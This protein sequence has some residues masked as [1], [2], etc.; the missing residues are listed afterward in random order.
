MLDALTTPV[1]RSSRPPA[2]EKCWGCQ[3]CLGTTRPSPF[4]SSI[5]DPRK[6]VWVASSP[7]PYPALWT[8]PSSRSDLGP[9][10]SGNSNLSPGA[11]RAGRD[12]RI[13]R[14]GDSAEQF[15]PGPSTLF[16]ALHGG[17]QGAC[18]RWPD[19][20]VSKR[21]PNPFTSSPSSAPGRGQGPRPPGI[22]SGGQTLHSGPR[23]GTAPGPACASR[24]PTPPW[25]NLRPAPDGPDT[26]P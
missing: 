14:I 3:P 11:C 17:R 22:T 23:P 12:R 10:H 4:R 26:T 20:P 1:L 5:A 6:G 8:R 2:K 19:R 25:R 16:C 7:T 18:G 21:P 9:H 24:P 15:C 13:G